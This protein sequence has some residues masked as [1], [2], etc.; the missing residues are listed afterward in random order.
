MTTK[1]RFTV[2]EFLALPE[3]EPPSELLDGEVVQ[4]VSPNLKHSVLAAELV[5]LLREHVRARRLG[6]VGVEGRHIARD[7]GRVYLPDV[8]F[9]RSDRIPSDAWRGSIAATFAG[10]SARSLGPGLTPQV[11]EYPYD[12]PSLGT[13]RLCSRSGSLSSI[14]DAKSYRLGWLV[15]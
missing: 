13:N 12:L 11:F 8:H 2:D 3:T 14:F 5:G 4:K 7:E 10:M 15:E 9:T 1:T 6:I